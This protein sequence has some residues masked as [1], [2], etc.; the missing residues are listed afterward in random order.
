MSF[1]RVPSPVSTAHTRN[2][3]IIARHKREGNRVE[4]G[5]RPRDI[6]PRLA[7][8]Y[9]LVAPAFNS[10]K[11]NAGVVATGASVVRHVPPPTP[12]IHFLSCSFMDVHVWVRAR[13]FE[14]SRREATHTSEVTGPRGARKG[15]KQS[16]WRTDT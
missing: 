11:K 9:R 6:S 10:V 13:V 7:L 2:T 15:L 14:G 3:R 1:P 16:R 4:G 5:I 12:S 8:K